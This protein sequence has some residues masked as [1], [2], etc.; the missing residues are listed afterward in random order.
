[1]MQEFNDN[2]LSVYEPSVIEDGV[3]GFW[4]NKNPIE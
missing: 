2:S 1:M 3:N 4:L